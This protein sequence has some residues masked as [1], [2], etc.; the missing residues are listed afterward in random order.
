PATIALHKPASKPAFGPRDAPQQP[1]GEPA[2]ATPAA[3]PPRVSAPVEVWMPSDDDIL[4]VRAAR[5]RHALR[6]R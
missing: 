1:Q 4:P 6:L 5:R 2:P 3:A